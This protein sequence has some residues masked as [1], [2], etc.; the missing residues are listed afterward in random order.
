MNVVIT[1]YCRA[2]EEDA[3]L[4]TSSMRQARLEASLDKYKHAV[5]RFHFPDQ[6]VLQAKFRPRET[7]E[8]VC[9]K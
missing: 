2:K 5:I 8:F 1:C 3:P 4:M 7:G 6:L 9:Y